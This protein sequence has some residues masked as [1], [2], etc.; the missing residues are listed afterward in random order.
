MK[1]FLTVKLTME[2]PHIERTTTLELIH[3]KPQIFSTKMA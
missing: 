3:P 2:R 1:F